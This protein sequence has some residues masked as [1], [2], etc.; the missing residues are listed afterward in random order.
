MADPA[1]VK[2]EGN[3]ERIVS[4]EEEQ[5]NKKPDERE[6]ASAPVKST[7]ENKG[8]STQD[9]DRAVSGTASRSCPRKLQQSSITELTN[10][11]HRG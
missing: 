5:A 2:P 1:R 9:K 10:G 6:D 7:E 8:S 3:A 11:E 4:S